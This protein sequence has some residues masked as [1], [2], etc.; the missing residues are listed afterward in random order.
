MKNKKIEIFK[1][2]L[3]GH[4]FSPEFI[5]KA[6]EYFTELNE[7]MEVQELINIEEVLD[8]FSKIGSFTCNTLQS[9]NNLKELRED[10]LKL[11]NCD[12]NNILDFNKYFESIE[13]FEIQILYVLFYEFYTNEW[14]EE[15]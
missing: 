1:K 12:T 4:G 5:K 7:E 3:V 13:E 8:Y 9:E 11:F 2:N 14:E 10:I 15:K 6:L